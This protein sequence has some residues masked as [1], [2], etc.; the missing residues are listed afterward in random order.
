METYAPKK[1]E[2]IQKEALWLYVI[3][4]K[5][6]LE[7]INC[8]ILQ[9]CVALA[10]DKIETEDNICQMAT[11]FGVSK[12]DYINSIYEDLLERLDII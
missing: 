5:Q 2:E 1:Y 9:L 6:K 12:L 3:Q 7:E 10:V 8:S 4:H 11:M